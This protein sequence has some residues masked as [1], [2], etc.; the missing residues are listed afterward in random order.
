T[1]SFENSK[2]HNFRRKAREIKELSASKLV[3]FTSLVEK[4][5]TLTLT[6]TRLRQRKGLTKEE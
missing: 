1:F 3:K 5:L 6:A 2:F 4:T